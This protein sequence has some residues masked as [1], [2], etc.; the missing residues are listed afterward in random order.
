MQMRLLDQIRKNEGLTYSPSAA[1]APSSVFPGYGYLSARVEIPPAK[2]DGF[3]KDVDLI[4]QDLR[5][6]L[7][8]DDELARAKTPAIASLEK[9]RQTNEYWLTALAGAQSDPRKLAAIRTSQS[10]LA[11]ITA[12]DLQ[13]AAQTYL[14]DSKAWE[15]EVTPRPGR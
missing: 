14:D 7:V 2:L 1:N 13:H 9:R 8:G 12:A 11:R 4:A 5:T 3:F 15:L 6:R 10:Q